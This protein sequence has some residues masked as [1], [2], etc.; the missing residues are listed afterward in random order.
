MEH[1]RRSSELVPLRQPSPLSRPQSFLASPTTST[2]S[3]KFQTQGRRS[4]GQMASSYTSV[5]STTPTSPSFPRRL[6]SNPFDSD[7]GHQDVSPGAE[8]HEL[9]QTWNAAQLYYSSVESDDQPIY[10]S[11]RRASASASTSYRP[12]PSSFQ[13]PFQAHPGNP[14]PLPA[15]RRSGS[16]ESLTSP[17][18]RQMSDDSHDAPLQPPQASFMAMSRSTS[19]TSLNGSPNGSTIFRS[20]AAAAMAAGVPSAP[21]TPPPTFRAPFL[22]PSSRPS[23]VWTPPTFPY[24]VGSDGASASS[25]LVLPAPAPAPSTRLPAKLSKEDKPWLQR[26]A[27]RQRV[28]WWLTFAC[29][30]LGVAGAAALCFFGIEGVEKFSDS[31]LCMVLNDDFS[32]FDLSN[33]WTREVQLG[34]FGNGEFQIAS[35][36]DNNSYVQNGNLYIMPTLTEQ[37]LGADTVNNGKVTLD[38]CTT[39][40][41]NKT[42]CSASGNGKD[43]V[44]NPVMSARITTQDHYSI[45]YGR[46]EVSAKLPKGDWLW[47]AIW[48]LPVNGSWPLSGEMDLMEARGNSPSYPAQGTNF[49]RSTLQYGP[50]AALVARSYGWYGMKRSSFDQGFHTYGLEWD[51]TWMRFYVDSMVRQTLYISTKKS[52]DSFWNRA[53]F[54]ATAQNGSSEVVVENPYKSNNAPFNQPFYL[55]IDLAVGGTSGWFPDKVGGK[56]WLDGSNTAMYDF[57]QAKNSWY[58]TWPQNPEE[59][60][61][62]IESVKMWKKC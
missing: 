39:A 14:D 8:D 52:K 51:D 9:S 42:A 50:F 60:A 54:P 58:S 33:T 47:P 6:N 41:T 38:P 43:T 53:G 5:A 7:N 22:A 27:P 48:M 2:E 3:F 46:V 28:S 34:G 18:P 25:A 23:S 30:L 31:Q 12:P 59:G 35:S 21:G 55:I 19:N 36:F 32:T 26:A 40:Q 16:L 44:I 20:S 45:T 61:F 4:G 15:R 1:R 11:P 17:V 49:V 24:G 10:H 13:F 62:R 57:W 56:P 29:M 37:W